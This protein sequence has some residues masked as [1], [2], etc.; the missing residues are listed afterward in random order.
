MV[1]VSVQKTPDVFWDAILLTPCWMIQASYRI[2]REVTLPEVSIMWMV[3]CWSEVLYIKYKFSSLFQVFNPL[4]I[5]RGKYTSVASFRVTSSKSL[6]L[7][8]IS[9]MV[10]SLSWIEYILIW[11]KIQVG[12]KGLIESIASHVEAESSN[13]LWRLL[14]T[15]DQRL[16]P[17]RYLWSKIPLKNLSP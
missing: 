1:I 11:K 6:F 2:R 15:N 8:L 5:N 7:S 13:E 9:K 4:N 17:K 14:W 10:L 12:M 3:F 16:L